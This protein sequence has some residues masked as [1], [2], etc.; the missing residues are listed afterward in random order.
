MSGRMG[1]MPSKLGVLRGKLRSW[2]CED[3]RLERWKDSEE[4]AGS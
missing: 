2:G 3:L 4:E 1:G